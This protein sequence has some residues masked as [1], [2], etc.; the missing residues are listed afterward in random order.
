MLQTDAQK[1]HNRPMHN[2]IVSN[3]LRIDINGNLEERQRS[4]R[5]TRRKREQ[6]GVKNNRTRVFNKPISTHVAATGITNGER[7]LRGAVYRSHRYIFN[8]AQ[9]PDR[10][11]IR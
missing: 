9:K 4:K 2:Y 3:L 11:G 8:L 10:M 6:S 5:F 7:K 1:E